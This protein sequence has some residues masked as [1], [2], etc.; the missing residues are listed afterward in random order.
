[1]IHVLVKKPT[2]LRA[3]VVHT[4]DKWRDVFSIAVQSANIDGVILYN[5]MDSAADFGMLDTV[6]AVFNPASIH[7]LD[8]EIYK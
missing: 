6:Y 2:P 4:K 3:W 8:Y 5:T 7:I 1:M